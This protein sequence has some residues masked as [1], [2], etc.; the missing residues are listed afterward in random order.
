MNI[1]LYKAKYLKYKTK[2]SNLKLIQSGS[3]IDFKNFP[4]SIYHA[5][6]MKFTDIIAKIP[7][8][9]AMGFTHIQ[10]SP[11]QKCREIIG[12]VLM[13][14][15][16]IE[17]EY[18]IWWLAYQPESYNIGNFYGTEEEFKE[19]V[20]VAKE[21]GIEIVVDVVINHLQASQLFEYAIWNIILILSKIDEHELDTENTLWNVYN[22][23]NF[24]DIKIGAYIQ[25]IEDKKN[26]LQE[27]KNIL[28]RNTCGETNRETEQE[29]ININMELNNINDKIYT[30]KN[31][32][33]MTLYE[34]N[35]IDSTNY[36]GY[37]SICKK[38]K[39][40][41]DTYT[42][43]TKINNILQYI[44]PLID[45][46]YD[47]IDRLIDIAF[48]ELKKNICKFLGI[49]L[50][51]FKPEYYDIITPPY[52]CS[53]K[54]KF[55]HNCWLAQALPQL[56]QK[57]K[58]VIYKTFEYLKKLHTFGIKCLRI[59]AASHIQPKILKLYKKYF[60]KLTGNDNYIYS[61]VIN[62]EGTVK[63]LKIHD[64]SRITH[65]TEY[66]LLLKLISIFCF[67][68]DLNYLSVLE[69]PSG[70][71]GSVV[72][73]STHDLEKIDGANP[74]LSRF[75]DY[76]TIY[77]NENYKVMLMICY[78]LQR[79]YNVP[80]VFKTQIE[81]DYVKECCKFR[82]EL[83]DKGCN[84]EYSNTF[85]NT[86]F[87][88]TKYLNDQLLGT[89]YMNVSEINKYIDGFDI[90]PRGIFIKKNY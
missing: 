41:K 56:N 1:D 81:N 62:P 55:G 9:K 4:C 33:F 18:K 5:F 20:K 90:P 79:I 26:I 82:K 67:K 7:E 63:E 69:L 73:S 22:K 87:R 34:N 46:K 23:F 8:L 47:N 40:N 53:D 48:D 88:S 57:N 24:E 52:W 6:N 58:I 77:D 83:Y 2:Y 35:I 42:Q 32:I 15:K 21:N 29:I 45:G 85:D 43:D 74:A 10:P 50:E 30:I 17:Q 78:L 31:L 72:F 61:E 19:L 16:K 38:N 36:K 3:G 25:N 71:V 12:P 64:Y 68:C 84:K 66:N 75:G 28:H 13:K 54:I 51:H 76:N 49:E 37:E 14:K 80:L 60:D 70:D 86:I 11:I 27:K 59:D 89:F 65:I 39:D 44:L